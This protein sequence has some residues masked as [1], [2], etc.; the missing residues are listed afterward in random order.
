VY[1]KENTAHEDGK[2]CVRYKGDR[3]L[4]VSVQMLTVLRYLLLIV[5]AMLD[6]F[7]SEFCLPHSERA[8]QGT[9][10]AAVSIYRPLDERQRERLATVSKAP[11]RS[12]LDSY[13]DVGKP[14]GDEASRLAR[15]R[16]RSILP[17]SN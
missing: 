7:C 13:W 14:M 5:T 4:E 17:H 2:I 9:D 3:A 6:H 10:M 12:V 8:P 11:F 16:R 15:W 1:L